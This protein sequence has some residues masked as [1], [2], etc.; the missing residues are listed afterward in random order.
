MG[1]TSDVIFAQG[2]G[3][4]PKGL[5][6]EEK[7]AVSLLQKDLPIVKRPFLNL[8]MDILWQALGDTFSLL[9]Q[10]LPAMCIGLFGVEI[11]V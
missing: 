11:L 4:V 3:P 1:G 8:A 7:E 6:L 9:R 10:V 2:Q 5:S